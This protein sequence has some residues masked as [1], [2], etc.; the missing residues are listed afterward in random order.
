MLT[1]DFKLGRA[2]FRIGYLGDIQQAKANNL[3]Q[4]AYTH[5]LVLGYVSNLKITYN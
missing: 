2:H 3:K 4:H 5:A 1:L